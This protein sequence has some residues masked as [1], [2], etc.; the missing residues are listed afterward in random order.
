MK[1]MVVAEMRRW[2]SLQ[3]KLRL[4]EEDIAWIPAKLHRRR[5]MRILRKVHRN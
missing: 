4:V 3:M 5:G 1:K 2:K